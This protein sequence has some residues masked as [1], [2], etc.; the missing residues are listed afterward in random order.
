M[1]EIPTTKQELERKVLETVVEVGENYKANLITVQ[2]A[3]ARIHSI[4]QVTAGLL[5]REVDQQVQ[6]FDV[7]L[8][9][10]GGASLPETLYLRQPDGTLVRVVYPL[11]APGLLVSRFRVGEAQP[12]VLYQKDSAS[13]DDRRKALKALLKDMA[14][15]GYRII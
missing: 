9:E 4:W 6:A 10:E 15:N 11:N 1:D 14:G 13:G 12:Q 2:E 8:L 5:D 3:R 7:E